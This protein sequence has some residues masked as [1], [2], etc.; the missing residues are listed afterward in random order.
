MAAGGVNVGLGTDGAASNNRLDLFE[1]MRL[2]AL[3]AKG[4]AQD[5][6]ALSAMSAVEMA[7][8]GGARA[9]G[10]DETIGSLEAGKAADMI[11]VAF[12]SPEMTPMFD[13]FS[14]LVYAAG[15]ADVTHAWTA[16]ECILDNRRLVLC[17]LPGVLRAALRWQEKLK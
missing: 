3:I 1:E 12:D 17:D 14:H 2:A 6:T 7:T 16:G 13:P 8:L 15:R 10:L 11:A 4:A 9:L 5:P